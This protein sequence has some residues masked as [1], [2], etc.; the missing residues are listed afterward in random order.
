MTYKGNSIF[1]GKFFVWLT[2]IML[3]VVPLFSGLYWQGI[4]VLVCY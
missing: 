3:A 4:L 2:L 1:K